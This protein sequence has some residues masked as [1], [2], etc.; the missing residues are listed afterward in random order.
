M[1][2][3]NLKLKT[4]DKQVIVITGASSGIGLATAKLAAGHGAKVVLASRHTAALKKI[5]RELESEGA[6][7]M[8]VTTDVSKYDDLVRLK[9]EAMKRYK[10]IDTWINNAGTSIYGNL[11]EVPLEDER[12][13]FETNY[14]GVCY[15]CRVAVPVLERHGGAL[16]NLGSEVSEVAIPLQGT[17]SATK[18]AIKAYTDALRLELIKDNKPVSVTLVRPS[19]I[20]TPYTKHAVN[21]LRKGAPDLPPPIYDVEIVAKAILACAEKKQRDAY[22]GFSSRAFHLLETLAPALSDFI[23]KNTMFEPQTSKPRS[24]HQKK[25]ESLKRPPHAEGRTTEEYD[26]DIKE[27]SLY[28]NAT[29]GQKEEPGQRAS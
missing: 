6:D 12:A 1:D 27:S 26:E 29:V 19:S 8:Y 24:E 4:I 14:W 28:T 21:H 25:Y 20:N 13:L 15:G 5:C 11:M 7:V 17:Y 23:L 3:K 9:D 2:Y 22:I 18:H 16:I 10:R